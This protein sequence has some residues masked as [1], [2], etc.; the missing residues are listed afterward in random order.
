MDEWA[1][2]DD[3]VLCGHWPPSLRGTMRF[4]LLALPIRE[5]CDGLVCDDGLVAWARNAG[6]PVE[7][8]D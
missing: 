5:V 6:F 4:G 7:P 1:S 2:E 3:C 8:Q